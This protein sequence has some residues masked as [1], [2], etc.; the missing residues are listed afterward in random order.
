MKL[1]L[2]GLSIEAVLLMASSTTAFVAVPRNHKAQPSSSSSGLSVTSDLFVDETRDL[3]KDYYGK[4]LS[5]SDDLKTDA[6]CTAGAPPEYIQECIKKIHPEVV[7]R[8]YGCGLCLPQYPLEGATVLDLGSGSGR[9]VYIASQLVGP[10][11]KVSLEFGVDRR[12]VPTNE[13]TRSSSWMF[14]FCLRSGNG[15]E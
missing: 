1:S 5:S 7:K 14:Y 9:D 8:Y 15:M 3:V 12:A 11:G 10:T 13:R 2:L 4:E 6:C